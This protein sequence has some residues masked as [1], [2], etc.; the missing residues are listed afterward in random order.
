[1][2]ATTT[3][4]AFAIAASLATGQEPGKSGKSGTKSSKSGDC[5]DC[6][7]DSLIRANMLTNLFYS[8]YGQDGVINQAS[9]EA[10]CAADNATRAEFAE[11]VDNTI[12]IFVEG[13]LF[14]DAFFGAAAIGLNFTEG[15][16]QANIIGNSL[17]RAEQEGLQCTDDPTDEP[18]PDACDVLGGGNRAGPAIPIRR[19]L[20]A[21]QS[22]QPSDMKS[23]FKSLLNLN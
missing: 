14:V 17:C 18:I 13:Q 3:A 11:A 23:Y 1:M 4:V 8:N 5:T 21:G 22:E 16:F 19:A 20:Q 15:S 10:Y 2:R 6:S 7:A 9:V 12:G